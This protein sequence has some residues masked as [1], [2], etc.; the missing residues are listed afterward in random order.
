[1]HIVYVGPYLVGQPSAGLNRILGIARGFVSLDA[2]VT[3]A[4][5]DMRVEDNVASFPSGIHV[6]TTGE[7]GEPGWSKP[8]KL[9]RRLAWGRATA[10]MLNRLDPVPDAVV[11]YGGGGLFLSRM[12]TWSRRS[13]TPLI[14]DSVEWYDSRHLPLGRWGPLAADNY[15]AMRFGGLAG[16]GVIA[17]STFLKRHYR[18]TG[19][20]R[21]VV[22]PPTLDVLGT[23]WSPQV[24]GGR[25]RLAY[26]GTP[27]K[28]DLLKEVVEAVLQVDPD[29][30]AFQFDIAGIDARTLKLLLRRNVLPEHI[31][32]LG[33]QSQTASLS[34]MR[35]AHFV[36]LLRPYERYAEAGYPTKIVE[37]LSVGTPVIANV[38]S[39]LG[40]VLMDERNSVVIDGCTTDVFAE[41]LTRIQRLDSQTITGMRRGARRTA[42]RH[43]D[44][45]AHL[46]SLRFLLNSLELSRHDPMRKASTNGKR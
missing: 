11:V 2:R 42:E 28:K 12:A 31:R 27:G 39:D 16:D 23:E 7:L 18:A 21:V 46:D 35:Q 15:L 26:C 30:E 29:G 32:A 38:T 20:S 45:R 10:R 19:C 33:R 9:F 5:G 4:A 25:I 34:L 43:F 22:I 44:Y 14:V 1:M 40:D 24:S 3:L 8:R 41:A 13:G 6:A 17:I 37:S 36:P